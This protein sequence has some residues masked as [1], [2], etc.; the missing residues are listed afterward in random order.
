MV[1]TGKDKVEEFKAKHAGSRKS[2]DRFVKLLTASQ[3]KNFVE[4]KKTFPAADQVNGV[5]IFDVQ[6]NKVRVSAL[7]VYDILT[8]VI[9]QVMTHDEYSKVK[10]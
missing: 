6:G 3:S 4:L 5:T 8:V 7:V 1:V 2:L 9:E 10:F